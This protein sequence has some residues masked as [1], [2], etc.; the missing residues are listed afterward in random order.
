[1]SILISVRALASR[2]VAMQSQQRFALP[3]VKHE[4]MIGHVYT[5]AKCEPFISAGASIRACGT[6]TLIGCCRSSVLAAAAA[7]F[8]F[9]A[10]GAKIVTGLIFA[11]GFLGRGLGADDAL[12]AHRVVERLLAR[13]RRNIRLA[14]CGAS[15]ASGSSCK[16]GISMPFIAMQN[17]GCGR[18]ALSKREK[19]VSLLQA[20]DAGSQRRLLWIPMMGPLWW[21]HTT[22]NVRDLGMLERRLIAL[23]LVSARKSAA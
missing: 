9:K 19:H 18:G 11:L 2:S 22:H 7:F 6:G 14:G 3:H 5:A 1:M 13:I 12:L 16:R 15:G 20:I 17:S 4:L 23:Q 21:S 8:S 10:Y